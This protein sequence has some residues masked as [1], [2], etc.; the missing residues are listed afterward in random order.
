[1]ENDSSYPS[2]ANVFRKAN[3]AKTNEK[4]KIAHRKCPK[5]ECDDEEDDG[6]IDNL[7]SL[8][9]WYVWRSVGRRGHRAGHYCIT[10]SLLD[11]F[12]ALWRMPGGGK[13]PFYILGQAVDG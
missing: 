9:C 11:L 8:V 6:G 12:F 1:L 2:P 7:E 10:C 3:G 5:C 13:R 4:Q